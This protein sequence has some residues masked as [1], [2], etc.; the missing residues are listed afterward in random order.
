MNDEDRFWAALR[1]AGDNTESPP[2]RR[3]RAFTHAE[4]MAGRIDGVTQ[5]RIGELLDDLARRER[6]QVGDVIGP[7]VKTMPWDVLEFVNSENGTWRRAFG[8]ERYC[9]E[10]DGTVDRDQLYDWVTEGGWATSEG[11]LSQAPLR[12]TKV[13]VRPD[14]MNP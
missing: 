13:A 7:N 3:L 12:V 8:D 1:L 11:A 14:E 4:V 9:T 6:S 5:D 2:L 10:D